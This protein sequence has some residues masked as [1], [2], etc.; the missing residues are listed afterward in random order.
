[1]AVHYKFPLSTVKSP[2][3]QLGELDT[4]LSWTDFFILVMDVLLLIFQ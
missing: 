4:S 2:L 3:S 1:M